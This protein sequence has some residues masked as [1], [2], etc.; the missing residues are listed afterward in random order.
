VLGRY[1]AEHKHPLELGDLPATCRLI[2]GRFWWR[3]IA[4]H[5]RPRLAH[6]LWAVLSTTMVR[7]ST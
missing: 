3:E 4:R 1:A 5:D 6:A 2:S 7:T